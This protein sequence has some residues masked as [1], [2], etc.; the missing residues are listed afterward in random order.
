MKQ[1]NITAYNSTQRIHNQLQ[2]KDLFLVN[3]IDK[4]IIHNFK[5]EYLNTQFKYKKCKDQ[6]CNICKFASPFYL[7]IKIPWIYFALNE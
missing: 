7:F 3:E 2:S 6:N 1:K 5:I 4:N